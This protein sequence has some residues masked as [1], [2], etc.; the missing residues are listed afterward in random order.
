MPTEARRMVRKMRGGAQAHLVEAADGHFYVVKFLNNPQ[1]RRVLTNE[2]ISSAFLKY[3]GVST[4][5]PELIRI[6]AEFLEDNPDVHLQAGSER[7]RPEEGWHFGSR[8]PGDPA[9]NIVYDFLPDT[10]LEKVEN[11]EDFHGALAFDQWMANADSRQAVFFRARLK[12]WLPLSG[13]HPLR[14][15][16]VAQMVDNGYVFNGPQWRLADSPLQ[17]VYFRPAV[18]RGARSLASFDPWIERIRNFPVEVVDDAVKQ[19]PRTWL[20]GEEDQ[21]T[22]LLEQLIQR[23]K[24]IAD[25]IERSR[26]ERK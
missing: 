25:L 23:R 10:L 6:T 5:E 20:E 13:S 4:P 3:L 7:Q 15:G 17:G 1:H 19:I 18:Y 26:T 12:D 8:Y 21:L 11:L 16:F 9:R 24:R 2:W 22:R 14:L